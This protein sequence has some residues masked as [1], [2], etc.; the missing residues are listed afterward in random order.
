MTITSAIV[1]FAVIWFLVLFIVLPVNF[2]SQDDT[3][4]VVPGTPGSAPAEAGMRRKAR[5]TTIIAAGLWMLAA[6]FILSGAVSIR[7]LDW[8]SRM[9]PPAAPAGG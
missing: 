8:F 5:L 9:S 1:L 4:K 2:R 6:G 7:D 3:G